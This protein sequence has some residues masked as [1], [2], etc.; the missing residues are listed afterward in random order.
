VSGGLEPLMQTIGQN[1]L[2][3][4]EA[5][6][7]RLLAMDPQALERCARL[8]GRIIALELTDL[9]ITIHFHPGSWGL[10]LSL[11]TPAREP[12]ARIRGRLLGLG[13]LAL[14]S[15]PPGNAIA[16][17]IEI[18]GD[19]QTAQGFQQILADIDIDGEEQLA[20]W[21]GDIPAFRIGQAL[22]K[23]QA[24]FRDNLRE[25]RLDGSEYLR[26]EARMTP[27]RPEFEGFREAVSDL[28]H[29]VERLQMLFERLSK[30]APR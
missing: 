21:I 20:Q 30:T 4:G 24:T 14:K 28:R 15:G 27:T 9:G 29:D 16:E 2:G 22:R 5:F 17:H 19:A 25:L 7:N 10:R 18:S 26:E 6:G 1:L 23:L 12:D 13:S 8:Q 3:L 11:Q